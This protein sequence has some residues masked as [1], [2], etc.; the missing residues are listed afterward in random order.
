MLKLIAISVGTSLYSF[1][2]ALSLEDG[3][4]FLTFIMSKTGTSFLSISAD[5]IF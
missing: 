3:L 4:I 1:I 2:G 5:K